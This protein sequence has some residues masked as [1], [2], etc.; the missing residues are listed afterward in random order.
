MM[1]EKSFVEGNSKTSPYKR[2]TWGFKS[3][4]LVVW[5]NLPRKFPFFLL[6]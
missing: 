1:V 2:E 5:R 6:I 3:L 4:I